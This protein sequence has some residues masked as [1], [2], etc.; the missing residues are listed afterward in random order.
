[1]MGYISC[2]PRISRVTDFF[3]HFRLGFSGNQK[4]NQ[5]GSKNRKSGHCNTFLYVAGMDAGH[6][7]L[8]GRKQSLL[9]GED[10]GSMSVLSGSQQHNVKFGPAILF[11]YLPVDKFGIAGSLFYRLLFSANAEYIF[12]R[13]GH[14]PQKQGTHHSIITIG[15][16]GRNT[17]FIHPI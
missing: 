1:M 4:N 16:F 8:V 11:R 15:I 3:H 17:A 7:N 14:Y 5:T 10:R 12:V 9:S 13:N 2:R 6:I